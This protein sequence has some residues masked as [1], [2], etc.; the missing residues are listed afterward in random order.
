M[1]HAA[2]DGA[3]EDPERVR[4]CRSPGAASCTAS[5]PTSRC[6]DV[7]P[8]GLV[9]R[10]LAPGVSAREVQEKTEP[11]LP[12]AARRR[13][14]ERSRSRVT[15][16]A[17]PKRACRPPTRSEKSTLGAGVFRRCDG[18]GE[19]SRPASSRP[20]FEVCPLCGHHHKLD[21]ARLAASS[22]STT[23]SSRRGT[24]TS[25][26][27]DPLALQRRQEPTRSASPQSQKKTEVARRPSRSA[28]AA[29]TG[30]PIAY[31][32][33][34]FAFMGGSMGS[35]VGE[36]VTRLFERGASRTSCPSCCSRPRA[37]RAC[38]RASSRS[39]R[40]RRRVAAL[41][42]LPR[43]AACRSSRVLL[44]P[45]T[46]GVAASFAFLGDVNIAEPKALIGFAG[47]RV[48]ENDHP[49]DAAP[50]FQRASSCS[51]TG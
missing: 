2:K 38:R 49:P 46:G 1:E 15:R 27:S 40:W 51:S 31:G 23:A 44:H 13:R 6:I 35:V 18:C 50:G 5:S 43:G 12:G 22:C 30:A 28:A 20:N 25:C 4:R 39:C 26:P 11:T 3:P 17:G 32:A 47:P 36:K 24:R 21:G 29:S 45:T 41:E 37:A 33:F 16:W 9:L 10:E 19:T 14:D 34:I 8:E 7:T 42:R 48:I